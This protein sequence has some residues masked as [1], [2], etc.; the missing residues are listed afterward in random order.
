[1]V[2]SSDGRGLVIAFFHGNFPESSQC[3]RPFGA[4]D[5]G[6]ACL[7][8]CRGPSHGSTMTGKLC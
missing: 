2:P 1:M 3:K 8:L 6:L 5:S 7:G 4:G